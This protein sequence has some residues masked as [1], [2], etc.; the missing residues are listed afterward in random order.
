L[1]HYIAG[2]IEGDGSIKVPKEKR[3]KEG[4]LLYPSITIIFASKDL[5]LAE[6]LASLLGGTINKTKGK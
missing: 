3:S 6:L 4:Q 2:I 5:P 1:S